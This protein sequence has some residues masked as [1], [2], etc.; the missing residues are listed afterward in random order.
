M[1]DINLN[2]LLVPTDVYVK[3]HYVGDQK[4]VSSYRIYKVSNKVREC[5]DEKFYVNPHGFLLH[6]QL[7]EIEPY[8][9]EGFD[10]TW[11]T[12]K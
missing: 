10:S 1:S 12:N 2:K 5:G 6:H 9:K 8:T 4:G 11:N 7:E 3:G